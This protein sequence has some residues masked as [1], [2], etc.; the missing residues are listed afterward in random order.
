MIDSKRQKAEERGRRRLSIA[1][2]DP[3]LEPSFEFFGVDIRNSS[4]LFFKYQMLLNSGKSISVY[5]AYNN[6]KN[7]WEYI[8][9]SIQYLREVRNRL[10]LLF[11][12]SL[13]FKD[14]KISS[15]TPMMKFLSIEA[16]LEQYLLQKDKPKEDRHQYK[17][18]DRDELHEEEEEC[19]NEED[20]EDEESDYS[21]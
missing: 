15:I 8:I 9:S 1:L 18:S 13:T 4:N 7:N 3:G 20:E 17:R 16:E 2:R 21:P 11:N 10:K 19:E 5:I 14:V 6:N 12:P